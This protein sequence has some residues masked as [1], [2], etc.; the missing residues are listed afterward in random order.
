MTL[1]PF[2]LLLAS[3]AVSGL[4]IAGCAADPSNASDDDADVEDTEVSADELQ[5]RAR[6]FVGSFSWDAATSGGFVDFETL[7]LD[8][9][10][11]YTAKVDSSLVNPAVR[12]IRF[13]CTLPESGSWTTVKSGG[14]LKIKVDPTGPKGSRSYWAEITPGG[15]LTL[16]RNGA[17]TTLFK[18]PGL[19]CANVRCAAGTHCEMKGINGGSIP[20]CVNNPP[21]LTCA[22]VLCAPNTTCTETAT[23][24][25]C[26]PIAQPACVKT[27]C[28]GQICADDHRIS[29]CEFRPE[30]A[31]YATARCERQASG[32]CG[33]TQTPALTSCLASH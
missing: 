8:A 6:Q 17:T 14:K 2:K 28:S 29:T 33:W 32:S 25:K 9:S 18:D 20:V 30:Y 1:A 24:P 31:C 21:A 3:L 16:K 23:G 26:V 13:P 15:A 19:T 5:S 7:K 4:A 27:G 12:C 10:G 22:S 11:K